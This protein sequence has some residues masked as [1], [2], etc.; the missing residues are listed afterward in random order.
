LTFFRGFKIV[1]T[2]VQ[3]FQKHN[4]NF[5]TFN[6]LLWTWYRQAKNFCNYSQ[7]CK[8]VIFKT[9]KSKHYCSLENTNKP[10]STKRRRVISTVFYMRQLGSYFFH[11]PILCFKDNTKKE[12]KR[13]KRYYAARTVIGW[14]RHQSTRFFR[15]FTNHF[16]KFRSLFIS[17][18]RLGHQF[19]TETKK[20][21]YCINRSRDGSLILYALYVLVHLGRK[22]V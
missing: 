10:W 8:N 3:L 21:A 17:T 1:P 18:S 22:Y 2:T 4:I 5:L 16:R 20:T 13:Y 7:R 19:W 12:Y 9:L 6:T 11:G 14:N 15:L